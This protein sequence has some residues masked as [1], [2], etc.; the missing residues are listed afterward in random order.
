ME[1]IKKTTKHP[2]HEAHMPHDHQPREA[3]YASRPSTSQSPICPTIAHLAVPHVPDVIKYD[4]LKM[5]MSISDISRNLDMI[6]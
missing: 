4:A 5:C 6:K 1:P 3:P 2:P